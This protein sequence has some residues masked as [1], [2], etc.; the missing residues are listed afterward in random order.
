M[1]GSSRALQE[2]AHAGRAFGLRCERQELHSVHGFGA[3][4]ETGTGC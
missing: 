1:S 3:K 4:I 2:L